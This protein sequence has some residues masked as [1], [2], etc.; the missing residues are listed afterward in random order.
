MSCG[1]G[2]RPAA[3]ALIKPLAWEYPYTTNAALKR[4]KTNKRTLE[5]HTTLVTWVSL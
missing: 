1:V 5:R 3:T 4:Q 2:R